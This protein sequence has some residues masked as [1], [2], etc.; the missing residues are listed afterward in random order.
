MSIPSQ[1]IKPVI[2]E[3]VQQPQVYRLA[4]KHGGQEAQTGNHR[5]RCSALRGTPPRDSLAKMRGRFTVTRRGIQHTVDAYI[6]EVT[7]D[8]TARQ[9]NC[10]HHPP[11]QRADPGAGTTRVNGT[12]RLCL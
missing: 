2:P 3:V 11:P 10:V 6:P 5:R 4:A 1:A 8:S 9:N 12:R 7:A